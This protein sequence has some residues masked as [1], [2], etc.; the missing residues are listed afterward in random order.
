MVVGVRRVEHGR[1]R[2]HMLRFRALS[3]LVFPTLAIGTQYSGLPKEIWNL[4][5]IIHSAH[6]APT[7]AGLIS[8][9]TCIQKDAYHLSSRGFNRV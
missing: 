2:N 3:F 1:G 4:Y 9:P 6:S 8:T 5:A 7:D